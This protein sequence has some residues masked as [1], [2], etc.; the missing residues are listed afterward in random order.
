MG[1]EEGGSDLSLGT[2]PRA[3][4]GPPS[5]PGHLPTA[6]EPGTEPLRLDTETWR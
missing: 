3:P 4:S 1:R 5:R 6:L 2:I